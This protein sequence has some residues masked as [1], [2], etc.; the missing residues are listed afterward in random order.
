MKNLLLSFTLLLFGFSAFAQ[1]LTENPEP[2]K[3]Y[4]RCKTPD[5]WK[6][7]MLQL[8]QKQLTE[9]SLLTKQPT[10]QLQKKY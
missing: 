1:D 9:K 8:K 7:K 3:C 2:E 5:I 10:K 4:V 6:M